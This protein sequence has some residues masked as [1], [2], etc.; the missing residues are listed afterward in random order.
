MF[1]DEFEPKTL[2]DFVINKNI[3]H[4]I[5]NQSGLFNTVLYGPR[6]VGKFTLARKMINHYFNDYNFRIKSDT[7]FDNK[8]NQSKYHYELFVTNY[9]YKDKQSFLKTL[10]EFS[11]NKNVSNGENNVIIIKNAD[12]LSRNNLLILKKFSERNDKFVTFILTVKNYSKLRSVLGSFF[13]TRVPVSNESV[14]IDYL[15]DK[16]T[17]KKILG[18][19][20]QEL[21]KII[22]NND[23]NLTGIYI[24]SEILVMKNNLPE[25]KNQIKFKNEINK[26]TKRIV[27]NIFAIDYEELRN[28][29]YELT[30]RN[31]EKSEIINLILNKLLRCDIDERLKYDFIEIA[32][33]YSHRLMLSNKE[34]IQLESM[35]YEFIYVIRMFK[36]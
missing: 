13:S 36:E 20:V 2:T 22:K 3:A 12:L 16:L 29:I 5:L 14:I 9:N 1:L 11:S 34:V 31:I 7:V 26:F 23:F 21:S 8:I 30:C 28:N 18:L 24:D 27:N 17:E 6:G 19:G 25:E 35:C 4:R 10:D 15:R 32:A 33:K